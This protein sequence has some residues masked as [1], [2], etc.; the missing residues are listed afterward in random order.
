MEND[1]LE[2]VSEGTIYTSKTIVVSSFFGGVLASSYMLY[3]NFKNFGEHRKA[4]LTIILTIIIFIAVTA[5][6][7][8][9]TLS[10]IPGLLFS[11]FITILTSFITNK[12]QLSL[13]SE[14]IAS[15]GKTFET[16]KAVAVCII[17]ILVYLAL[18]LGAFYL[19]ESMVANL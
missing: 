10:K 16:G 12:F 1:L 19:Q 17:G 9:P 3:H 2:K 7:F 4:S 11:I 18:A 6:A 8:S 14:H 15:Q 5:T 13:I